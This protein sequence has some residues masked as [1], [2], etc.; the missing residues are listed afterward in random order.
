MYSGAGLL[1]WMDK[2]TWHKYRKKFEVDPELSLGQFPVQS[3]NIEK[4]TLL[5][6]RNSGG[7]YIPFN[8]F[9]RVNEY[10]MAQIGSNSLIL[11]V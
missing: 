8:V 5:W 6:Q 1:K 4:K 10:N 11:F 7:N 2:P 9:D 3:R